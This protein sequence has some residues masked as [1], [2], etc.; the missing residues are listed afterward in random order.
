[1]IERHGGM[2]ELLCDGC[3]EA[4]GQYDDSDFDIMIVDAAAAGW[5][6][7]KVGSDWMHECPDCKGD[8]GSI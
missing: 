8:F 2:L 7:Y 3:G 5:D 1:M 6:I 4:L